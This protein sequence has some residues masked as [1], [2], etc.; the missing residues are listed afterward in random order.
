MRAAE[1]RIVDALPVPRTGMVRHVC[2]TIAAA[3][4]IFA[5][6][7]LWSLMGCP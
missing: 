5:A 1:A 6:A 2:G 7:F 4:S 3:C